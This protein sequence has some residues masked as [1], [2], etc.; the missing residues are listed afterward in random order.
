MKR[1]NTCTM[2][3]FQSDLI[4]YS[5]KL[6]WFLKAPVKSANLKYTYDLWAH[7]VKWYYK[8]FD[9]LG[10]IYLVTPWVILFSVNSKSI[11]SSKQKSIIWSDVFR[12]KFGVLELLIIQ[13]WLVFLHRFNSV[14]FRILLNVFSLVFHTN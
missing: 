3:S 12:W 6:T 4:I 13:L 7:S 9:G 10:I 1:S 2:I 14:K 8:I 11:H 5:T